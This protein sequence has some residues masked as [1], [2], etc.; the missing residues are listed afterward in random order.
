MADS[1]PQSADQ[2][3][4][5]LFTAGGAWL[6]L[7]GGVHSLSFFNPLVPG[8]ETERQ[9]LT[10]MTGYKFNLMG[11]MRSMDNLLTGFSL[12]FMLAALALG[13]LALALRRQL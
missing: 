13:A 5:R 12:A 1:A 2:W 3:G 9:L 6:L 10:L 4:H 8:N 11:S 7:L